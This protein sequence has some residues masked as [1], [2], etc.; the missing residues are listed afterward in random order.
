MKIGPLVR[1]HLR[2]IGNSTR[3]LLALFNSTGVFS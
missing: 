2:K 3:Q 1:V